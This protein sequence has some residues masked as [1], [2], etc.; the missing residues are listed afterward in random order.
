MTETKKTPIE[1]VKRRIA[2]RIESL[3]VQ[4][5]EYS[6]YISTDYLHFFEVNAGVVYALHYELRELTRYMEDLEGLTLDEAV[7]MTVLRHQKYVADLLERPLTRHSTNAFANI[8]HSI[9][10]AVKQSLVHRFDGLI[11][12]LTEE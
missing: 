8:A 4:T 1:R 10:L 9:E 5:D 12:I 7:G 3:T 6:K 2:S 11:A